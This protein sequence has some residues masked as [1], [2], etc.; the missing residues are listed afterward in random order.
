MSNLTLDADCNYFFIAGPN[1]SGKSIYL[2]QI[3]LI[4]FLAHIG[5]YVPAEYANIGL[6]KSIHS[7]L[8]TTES[9]SVRLSAFMI[10]ITQVGILQ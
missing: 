3:A 4:T 8:Q 2:K 1:G 5:S 6:T 10:D 9:A 7:R